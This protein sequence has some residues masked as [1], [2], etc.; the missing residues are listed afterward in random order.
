M[1]HQGTFFQ[2]KGN[3]TA[4]GLPSSMSSSLILDPKPGSICYTNFDNISGKL[5]VKC[6]KDVIVESIVVKLEGETRTRLMAPEGPNG[7]KPRPQLERHKVGERKCPC[8]QRKC[9]LATYWPS[10][11]A[12]ATSL[13]CVAHQHHSD[14]VV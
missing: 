10:I 8:P 1:D 6:T 12:R 2:N 4:I 13:T 11:Y 7:E 9:G 14:G 3:S 5:T